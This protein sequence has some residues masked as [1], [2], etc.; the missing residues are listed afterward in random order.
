MVSHV[1][2]MAWGLVVLLAFVSLGRIMARLARPDGDWDVALAAGWG[3][4]GMVALGGWMTLMGLARAPVLVGLV[5]TVI[6]LDLFFEGRRY[7]SSEPRA[8]AVPRESTGWASW[9]WLVALLGVVAVIYEMSIVNLFNTGDDPVA[10]LLELARMLQTGSVGPDPFSERLMLALNGQTFLLGLVGSVCPYYYGFLLDPGVCDIMI[11]GLVWF[12][13][14]RDLGGSVTAAS[15]RGR[16][17]AHDQDSRLLE[18]GR[19]PD[20]NGA[21]SDPAPDCLLGLR[22]ERTTQFGRDP[23]AGVYRGGSVRGQ[24]NVPLLYGT[25]SLVLVCLADLALATRR[26]RA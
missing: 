26:D 1:L 15:D 18:P 21:L 6:A 17:G 3:M 16:S 12:F 4:A 24:D 7:F 9:I 10:Y 5:I 2:F 22:R 11:A 8:P 14:R 19:K 20:G 13:V 25:V 23:V